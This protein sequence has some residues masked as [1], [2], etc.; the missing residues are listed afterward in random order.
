MFC[1]DCGQDNPG[2][3]RFCRSCGA[4]LEVSSLAEPVG[5]KAA[6]ALVDYAGFWI[7]FAAWIIDT[8]I[9]WFGTTEGAYC[10]RSRSTS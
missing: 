6:V 4:A 10:S 3:A 8:V 7:R 5:T 9:V 2:E 1:P